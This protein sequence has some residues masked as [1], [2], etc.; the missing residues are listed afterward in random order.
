MIVSLNKKD[1][2]LER[3]NT[4]EPLLVNRLCSFIML[5]TEI[6]YKRRQLQIT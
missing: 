4:T 1:Q 3:W 2:Y 6:I 5:I